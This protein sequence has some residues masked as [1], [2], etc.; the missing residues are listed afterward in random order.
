MMNRI[1]RIFGETADCVKGRSYLLGDLHNHCGISYGHGSIEQAVDFAC[2]QLD[3]FSVTGHYAWPDIDR[4]ESMAIPDDVVEYH[5]LGFERLR[6]NWPH[7]REV[8]KR[9][10]ENGTEA[11]LSYEYHSFLTG[12]YTVVLKDI[13]ADLP[14]KA[15]DIT[16][17][18][19]LL[20]IIADASLSDRRLAFPHHIGYK[21]GFRGINWEYYNDKAC[22]LIEIISMHGC[23]EASD[24]PM[25]Y[26]HTMGPRCNENTMRS[27]LGSGFRFGVL[28]CTDHHNASPGSYGFGRTG[29]WSEDSSRDAIWRNLYC[30]N[31]VALSGDPVEL[32][33]NCV[34][35]DSSHACLEGFAAGYDELSYVQLICDGR[36]VA[37]YKGNGPQNSTYCIPFGFGWGKKGIPCFWRISVEIAGSKIEKVVPRL[38]GEDIVA[39]LDRPSGS[40]SRPTFRSDGNRTDMSFVTCGNINTTSDNTQGLVAELEIGP[41]T[42]VTVCIDTEWNGRE[43]HFEHTYSGEELISNDHVEYIDGF[44][45]PCM[46]LGKAVNCKMASCHFRTDVDISA[47]S[48]AYIRLLQE[49]GSFAVSSPIFL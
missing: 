25:P 41:D 40:I 28:G 11:F 26:L 7:Y 37:Q 1:Y 8:M 4:S 16:E 5:R 17:E 38:R 19:R 3:F 44:V 23:S 12:D 31:T 22:P 46:R 27:G 29:L 13:L 20:E 33:L 36:L 39:P 48:Y 14:S 21:T 49:N 10:Q 43:R 34:R 32:Y 15:D 35:K 2:Q 45:S 30:R 47:G 42:S 24:S 18:R 9:A 6:R